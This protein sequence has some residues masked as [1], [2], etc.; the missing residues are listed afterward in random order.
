MTL[1]TCLVW[2]RR[3][4]LHDE[5]NGVGPAAMTDETLAHS[6]IATNLVRALEDRLWGRRGL[7]RPCHHRRD[8]S[9]PARDCISVPVTEF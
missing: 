7:D 9:Q 1:D 4:G 5:F 6:V 2:E 3:Q 8:R